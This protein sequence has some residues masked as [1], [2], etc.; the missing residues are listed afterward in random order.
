[1]ILTPIPPAALPRALRSV[2]AAS[3]GPARLALERIAATPAE[4]ATG[5]RAE[6]HRR[7]ALALAREFGMAAIAGAPAE[8]FHW[9]G[10]AL[11]ADSEAYVLL[12]EVAHFQVAAPERRSLPEFGLGAGPDTLLR[13]EAEGAQRVF[14]LAREAEEAAASLLGI[15]WEAALGHPALASFLDQNWLEGW[16]RGAAAAHFSAV[17]G[18]LLASRLVGEEGFPRRA[19]AQPAARRGEMDVD[20]EAAL[21]N[22]GLTPPTPGF[23]PA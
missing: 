17:Y 16:H 3:C 19:L 8:G 9:N 20:R 13:A 5:E 7:E 2:A 4:R 18:D 12:H 11:R 1:M 15:L 14:G 22:R 23:E 6:R 21:V 10:S